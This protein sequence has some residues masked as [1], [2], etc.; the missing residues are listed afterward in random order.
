MR[1]EQVA[2]TNR[3]QVVTL[4]IREDQR[5]F[6]DTQSLA[7]FLADAHLHPTFTPHAL[8]E[9]ATVVGF[10]SVGYLPEA[11]TRWWIPLL[12]IDERFQ[13]IG[14]GRAAMAAIIDLV[15]HA[16]PDCSAIGLGYKPSNLVAGRLYASL[17]FEPN[18]KVDERGE[19]ELWL[20]LAP[21]RGER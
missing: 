9:G 4:Q 20:E 15:R 11:R 6:L 13:G 2:G 16:T 19:V 14:H 21:A 3:G 10:A 8:V 7:E 1:L 5:Q 12:I 17:G 18:G